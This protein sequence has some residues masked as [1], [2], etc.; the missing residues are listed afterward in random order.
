MN[1]D[2]PGS[3]LPVF[4][5][6]LLR[7]KLNNEVAFTLFCGLG[8]IPSPLRESSHFLLTPSYEISTSIILVF[9]DEETESREIGGSGSENGARL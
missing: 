2:L 3:P 9:I 8:P 5:L 4:Q 1:Q 7:N 6:I